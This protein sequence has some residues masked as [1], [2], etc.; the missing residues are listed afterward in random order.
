VIAKDKDKM[1]ITPYRID[2]NG[3]VKSKK[4]KFKIGIYKVFV[5]L[6]QML[7]VLHL[8]QTSHKKELFC[9]F[10]LLLYLPYHND[11]SNK[12]IFQTLLFHETDNL[13]VSLT[14]LWS[15]ICF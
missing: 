8:S 6:F 10:C 12:Q 11:S 15:A 4:R 2:R 3:K 13:F 1:R 9:I 5:Y 7:Q 14:P